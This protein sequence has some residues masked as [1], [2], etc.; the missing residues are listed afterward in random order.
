VGWGLPDAYAQGKPVVA[1]VPTVDDAYVAAV[2]PAA[3][4]N[5][6]DRKRQ[7][8]EQIQLLNPNRAWEPGGVRTWINNPAAWDEAAARAFLAEEMRVHY[9]RRASTL[10][11]HHPLGIQVDLDSGVANGVLVVRTVEQCAQLVRRIIT[12]SLEFVVETRMEGDRE[13]LLLR[14]R[15]SNSVYRVMT[16]DKMLTNTFWNYYIDE[17]T[18]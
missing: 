6:D 9:D 12:R 5:A 11:E 10:K 13:Y 4:G 2:L 18:E 17:P 14:E 3:D 7:I 16:G 1:F 15:I 8:L